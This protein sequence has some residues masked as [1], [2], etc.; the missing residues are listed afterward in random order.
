MTSRRLVVV[1][2]ALAG[3]VSCRRSTGRPTDE[4]S[5]VLVSID[6]LRADRLALYGYRPGATPTFDRLGRE[7]IVFDEAYSHCPLTL[8]AHSSLFTG[9]LPPQHGV[10][11][12]L[13]FKLKGVRTLAARFKARGLKTGGAVS[14]FV[15]R[16]ETGIAQGFDVWD[17]EVKGGDS[18]LTAARDGAVAV[19]SVARWIESQGEARFFAFLHLYE[20]HAPYAPPP[21]YRGKDLY[22]GEVSYA[23]DL[24][25]RLLERL[26]SRGLLDRV[27]L[28]VTAD[29]GEGLLDHGEQEHGVFLYRETQWIPLVLRLPQAA[30]GGTRVRGPVAQVDIPATLLDLAGLPADGMTGVSLRNALTSGRSPGRP[31]YSE[32][33]YPRF[34][35]GWSELLA[36]TETR[37]RYVRAPHPELYDVVADPGERQNRFSEKADVAMAMDAWLE[38]QGGSGP[39]PVPAEVAPEAR[40]RLEALGYV[41]GGA[42]RAQEKISALTAAARGRLPDPKDKIG[43]YESLRQALLAKS[44]GRPEQ[45]VAELQKIV[46]KNSR[47]PEA[48]AALGETLLRLDRSREGTAALRRAL[49]LDPER[50]TTMMALAQSLAAADEAKEALALYQRADELRRARGLG[51]LPGLHSGSGDCLARLGRLGEAEREMRAEVAAFPASVEARVRLAALYR[52]LGRG[53]EARAVL[54]GLVSGDAEAYAAILGAL[55]DLEDQKAATEWAQRARALF[56]A[57]PRFR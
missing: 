19:E 21:R 7:G 34:H 6:T 30:H 41:G 54:L 52:V 44:A 31:V 15:L 49:A 35:F 25:G 45:A 42:G 16:K 26:R 4:P 11:D 1:F 43:V 14:A 29:H 57:D 33:Y 18:P 27:I 10:R 24:L 56:P 55:Q 8:P 3:T 28:A 40:E 47:L 37:Y 50:L 13:G 12:N 23:D 5:V 22:D 9:L 46:A 39:A 36:A 51:E 2:L 32:T 17:D 20:P 48:W 53:K 38:T